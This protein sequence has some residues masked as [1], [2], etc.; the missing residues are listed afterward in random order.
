[1][2]QRRNN[3]QLSDDVKHLLNKSLIE[4]IVGLVIWIDIDELMIFLRLINK[5]LTFI[6][7]LLHCLL[8][9]IR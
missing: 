6:L 3:K 4:Y 1:M 9:E 7:Y 8:N 5:T 2:Q